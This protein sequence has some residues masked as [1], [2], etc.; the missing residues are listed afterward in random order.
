MVKIRRILVP[1]DFSEQSDAALKYAVDLAS[2]L[3]S[4]LLLLHAVEPIYFAG[5]MYGQV[6]SG[7]IAMEQVRDAENALAKLVAKVEGRKV[8]R[9]KVEHRKVGATGVV[10][11]GVAHQE[12]LKA[13]DSKKVDLIVMGTQGR[14]GINRAIMGSVAEKIVRAAKCPVLTLRQPTKT[15]SVQKRKAA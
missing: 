14:G 3:G 12:I 8:D 1:I 4:S 6:Y 7:P 11:S 15:T 10:A 5:A 9:R 2:E 13:A